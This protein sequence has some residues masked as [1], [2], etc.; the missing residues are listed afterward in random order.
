M[1]C[2]DGAPGC[3]QAVRKHKWPKNAAKEFEAIASTNRWGN[4]ESIS[5]DGSTVEI[6][7]VRAACLSVFIFTH[8][9][10]R[11]YDI[12]C[13]DAHW[14][15]SIPGVGTKFVYLGSDISSIA[16]G[17][18]KAKNKGRP[19]LHFTQNTTNLITTVPKLSDAAHSIWMLKEVVQHLPLEAGLKMVQ[20]VQRS[21]AHYLAITS[22]DTELFKVG[23]RKLGGKGKNKNVDVPYGGFYQNNVF[24]PPFNF[25]P[26]ALLADCSELLAT[27]EDQIR[28]GNLLIFD[29]QRWKLAPDGGE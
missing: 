8:N 6:N 4:G 19:H 13:G 5:G 2:L 23:K 7:R 12:P 26:S 18:A 3:A 11:L 20:N 16:L 9:V 29:L 1:P 25:P 24:L 17:Q 27:P 14:Q 10:T 28:R 21:G 15:H 22:H